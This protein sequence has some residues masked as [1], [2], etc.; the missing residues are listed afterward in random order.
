L[1]VD[2]SR[3]VLRIAS[4]SSVSATRTLALLSV[5]EYEMMP[6]CLN[7]AGD[8]PSGIPVRVGFSV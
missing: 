4:V 3:S 5:A 1:W 8:L 2:G 7:Q 6:R